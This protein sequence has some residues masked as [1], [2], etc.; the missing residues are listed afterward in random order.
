MVSETRKAHDEWTALG[1]LAAPKA[2][3]LDEIFQNLIR[4][5]YEL[6]GSKGFPVTVTFQGFHIGQTHSY[7]RPDVYGESTDGPGGT[8]STTVYP[9]SAQYIHRHANADVFLT[10]QQD[11]VYMC[12]KNAF[13]KWRCNPASG[14]KGTIKTLREQRPG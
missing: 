12:F 7:A 6:Q 10:Y 13:G 2:G 1:T 4:E 11:E 14:G 8:S 9:V 5:S 3:S